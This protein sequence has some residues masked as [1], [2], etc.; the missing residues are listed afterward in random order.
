MEGEKTYF[1]GQLIVWFNQAIN[2]CI[3]F[4]AE[5]SVVRIEMNP[6]QL[7]NWRSGT[8]LAF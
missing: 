8:K 4:Q 6:F 7:R 2:C 5:F 3:V 1:D